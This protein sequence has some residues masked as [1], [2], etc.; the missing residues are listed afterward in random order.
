VLYD[1]PIVDCTP[2]TYVYVHQDNYP[3]L[4]GKLFIVNAPFIFKGAWSV[5]KHFLE[6]RVSESVRRWVLRRP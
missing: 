1:I 6:V 5:I 3:E 2:S 4:M